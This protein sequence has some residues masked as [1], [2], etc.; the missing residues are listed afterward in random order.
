MARIDDGLADRPARRTL[1]HVNIRLARR[2]ATRKLVSA[3]CRNVRGR[4]C[5]IEDELGGCASGLYVEWL[6]C[7]GHIAGANDGE[8]QHS[9]SNNKRP[10]L[11]GAP[12]CDRVIPSPRRHLSRG[13]SVN[14]PGGLE[15]FPAHPV[16]THS[17]PAR[18][19]LPSASSFARCASIC[20]SA[21]GT[22]RRSSSM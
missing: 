15:S 9:N 19:T 17:S 10:A 2:A 8:N 18:F 11:H 5:V 12:S 3:T 13:W 20:R 22:I 14:G 16:S 4:K 21:I 7:A 6:F 1:L